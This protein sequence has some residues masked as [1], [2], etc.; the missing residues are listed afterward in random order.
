MRDDD[1]ALAILLAQI[2]RAYW[3]RGEREPIGHILDVFEALGYETKQGQ[4]P[5]LAHRHKT[6]GGWRLSFCLP[7][8]ISSRDVLAKLDHFE[9]Q[10]ASRIQVKVSGRMLHMDV[11]TVAMPERIPYQWCPSEGMTLGLPVGHAATGE[12]LSVDL[13][14]LPHIL[15]AGNTGSGKT[16]WLRGL[17]VSVI[18]QG[19]LVAVIDL[20]G[21]DFHH[22][23]THALVVDTER[24]ALTCLVALNK[25]LD[26]R[27][28]ILKAAGAVRLQDCPGLPWVVAVID[29][30]AELQDK[31]AQEALNRLARLSRAVGICLVTA[32]QR[33]SHTLFARFTDTRMLFAGRLCFHMPDP[34]DS[35]LILESDAAARIDPI[36]GRAVWRHGRETEVQCMDIGPREA[37]RVLSGVAKR[38]VTI[39]E[40]GPKRLP[41]R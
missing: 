27:K 37:Q 11:L 18:S 1:N 35:R 7:A 32:T 13:P 30:L 4:R 31:E 8:G 24:D 20:K 39:V 14:T 9:E 12:L 16:T 29:E 22:L 2:R 38:E 25:E 33:P 34:T 28:Q 19:A 10:S 36:P 6:P 23:H 5:V 41:A 17:C 26:R 3:H 40:P 15:V 21:L